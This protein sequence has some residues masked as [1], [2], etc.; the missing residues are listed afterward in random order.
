[1][2]LSTQATR[3]A[4]GLILGLLLGLIYGWLVRPV[5]YVNTSPDALRVDFRT[6]YVLMTAEAYGD[7]GDLDL[8]RFRLAALGPLPPGEYATQAIDYAL[9]QNFSRDD[10]ERL[11]KLA[12]A[13]RSLPDS[14]E[15]RQ[16]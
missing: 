14:G 5:E 10:V 6:D 9:Q 13:L 1:M 3:I 7:G 8:A 11:N 12:I 16:P 15:I 4:I 2:N